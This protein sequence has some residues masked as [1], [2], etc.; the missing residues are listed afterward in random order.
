[1]GLL[2][3]DQQKPPSKVL[4][5]VISGVALA[6]LIAVA[7]WFVFRYQPEKRVVENFMDA[8]V[9]GNMQQAYQIWVPH[10][11]YSFADFEGD[12]GASGYYGPVAS[13]HLES[14]AEPPN[15]GSGVIVT[16]EIS[17]YS[18]FPDSSDAKSSRTHEV[19]IW[20]E[21]SDKSLSFPP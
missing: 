12:W 18:P 1:M 2:D 8:V 10:P 11:S 17:P 3:A 15:G 21:R 20:V 4:R 16:V 7:L 5:Y 14:A 9:A 13:Y 6:A 19:Q